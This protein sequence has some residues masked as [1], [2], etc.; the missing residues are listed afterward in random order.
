MTEKPKPKT[1]AERQAK[2]RRHLTY[3]Y[4]NKREQLN[5]VVS[6]TAKRSLKVLAAHW[7]TTQQKALERVLIEAYDQ[8]LAHLN[9]GEKRA[10]NRDEVGNS[11]S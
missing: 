8:A 9:L 1:T 7:E 5:I 11:D 2:H 3:D 4:D 6:S 10:L